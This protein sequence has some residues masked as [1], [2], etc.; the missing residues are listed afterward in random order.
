MLCDLNG[1]R[2]N[3]RTADSKDTH[4]E[5]RVKPIMS[6]GTLDALLVFFWGAF[7]IC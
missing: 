7:F 1:V 2:Q 4:R 6:P 3:Q 5:K